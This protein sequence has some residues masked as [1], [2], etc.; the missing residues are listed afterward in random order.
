MYGDY[1]VRKATR[2]VRRRLAGN[3][4]AGESS[5]KTQLTHANFYTSIPSIGNYSEWREKKN[6][7]NSVIY[8]SSLSIMLYSK[9]KL[10]FAYETFL[11]EL[12]ESTIHD[13]WSLLAKIMHHL[14]NVWIS[15]SCNILRKGCYSSQT[16]V[17]Y[18]LSHALCLS[19]NLLLRTRYLCNCS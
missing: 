19:K 16:R 15:Y 12:T 2:H 4:A 5:P 9:L 7:H 14:L 3:L 11:I 17:R 18:Q 13:Q 10:L 6:V 1:T 8:N